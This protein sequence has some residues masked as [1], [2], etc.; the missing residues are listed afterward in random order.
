MG[1][2]ATGVTVITARHDGDIRGMTAN[3]FMSGS[4][5]PPLC[6]ISVAKRARMHA[7]SRCGRHFGVNILAVGQER[8]ARPFRRHPRPRLEAGLR[9]C[10]RG[11]DC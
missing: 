3:A 9:T 2:F 10:R 7:S 4:L 1:R 8:L 6:I 5:M 11:A